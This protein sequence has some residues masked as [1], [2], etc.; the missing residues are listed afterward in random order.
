MLLPLAARL[1]THANSVRDASPGAAPDQG[2]LDQEPPHVPVVDAAQLDE[3]FE[4]PA[5]S[6]IVMTETPDR[7]T[8]ESPAAGFSSEVM[9]L[10]LFGCGGLVFLGVLTQ[11]V[12]FGGQP[13]PGLQQLPWPLEILLVGGVLGVLGM[14][15]LLLI[16]TAVARAWG[17][18]LIVVDGG[19]CLVVTRGLFGARRNRL[20]TGRTA[21]DRSPPVRQSLRRIPDVRTPVHSPSA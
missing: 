6:Q 18:T 21:G 15:M 3:R 17:R 9:Q 12:L 2:S 4:Q 14:F 11:Q 16:L 5:G 8:F 7:L 20:G 1:A 13:Q 10:L 19:C